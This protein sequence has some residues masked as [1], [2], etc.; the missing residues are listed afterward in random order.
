[1]KRP[2]KFYPPQR[3]LLMK[4]RKNKLV[5]LTVAFVV[6]AAAAVFVVDIVVVVA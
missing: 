4:S 3:N 2:L 6:S 1:M 5:S